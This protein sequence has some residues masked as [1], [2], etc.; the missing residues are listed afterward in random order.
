[1]ISSIIVDDEPLARSLIKEFL[2][3]FE[4]IQIVAEAE[5]GFDAF[6]LIQLHKPDLLFLDIQMP[7]INGFEL[8]ELLDEKPVVVFTTAFDQFALKAFE[9]NA[10]DYLLKP[11][12]QQRFEQAVNKAL[13]NIGSTQDSLLL[14]GT[15]EKIN[16]IVVKHHGEIKIIAL[17][18]IDFIEACEDYIKICCGKNV[19]LKKQTMTATEN[20]LAEN[21]FVRIHRSYL[22]NIKSINKIEPYEK[23]SHLVVLKDGQRLS[24][25][26]TGYAKLKEV[27]G[28]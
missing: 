10:V 7:K 17:N 9:H 16:R 28:I 2:A 22:V 21:E 25:S 8:L 14:P 13:Q 4:H 12:T 1:M 19:Y 5:N 6:K 11:F 3:G 15:E 26:K 18:D 20:L 23:D 24:V 27:L